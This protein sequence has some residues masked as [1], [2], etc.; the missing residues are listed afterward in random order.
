MLSLRYPDTTGHFGF[1]INAT[2]TP[3]P[4]NGIRPHSQA[5]DDIGP[6][7]RSRLRVQPSHCKVMITY[8]VLCD[9]QANSSGTTRDKCNF[10][11]AWSPHRLNLHTTMALCPC[12]VYFRRRRRAALGSMRLAAVQH[13]LDDASRPGSDAG[14]PFPMLRPT[15]RSSPNRSVARGAA[16]D[17][18]E[19]NGK[20]LDVWK[21]IMA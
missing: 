15:N 8:E 11:H 2:S 3:R 4:K 21:A 20:C 9:G 12:L 6:H 13:G 14:G 16:R 19:T 1:Y 7:C 17:V 10:L 18:S 5:Y